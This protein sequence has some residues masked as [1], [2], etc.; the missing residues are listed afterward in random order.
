MPLHSFSRGD[1]IWCNFHPSPDEPDF[2]ITGRHMAV[3]LSDDLLPNRTVI[4]S[5]ITSW[6][7]KGKDGKILLDESGNPKYKKLEKF[8]HGLRQR[9]YPDFLKN[10]SYIKLDQIIT[11]TRDT[12]DGEIVGQLNEDDLFHVD[13]RLMI[14]LQMLDTLKKLVTEHVKQQADAQV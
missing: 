4:V 2:V 3:I 10:D 9:D 13:L 6:V 7:K 1:V 14:V 11:L 5:P 12:I 8:H